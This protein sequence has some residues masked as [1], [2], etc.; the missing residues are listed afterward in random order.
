MDW[1]RFLDI[2]FWKMGVTAE[3]PFVYN[4]IHINSPFFWIFL[5]IAVFF[6]VTGLGLA[7]YNQFEKQNYKK[8]LFKIISNHSI[9]FGFLFLSWF[10]ARLTTIFYL[11][12]PILIFIF[13]IYLIAI[14]VYTL[15]YYFNFYKIEEE[16]IQRLKK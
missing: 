10:L 4:P 3:T 13:V 6:S 1:S 8:K 7:I 12:A 15:R 16:Y 9:F 11:G 2:N 14:I 5:N